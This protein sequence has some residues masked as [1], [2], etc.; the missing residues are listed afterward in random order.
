[1]RSQ[2]FGGASGVAAY[3]Q[4]NKHKKGLILFLENLE[5]MGRGMEI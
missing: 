2:R 4:T 5:G 3:K 1:M